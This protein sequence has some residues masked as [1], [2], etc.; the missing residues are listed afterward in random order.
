MGIKKF[1]HIKSII[2]SLTGFI[3]LLLIGLI[4]F[5]WLKLNETVSI[6]E[7]ISITIPNHSSKTEIISIFNSNGLLEPGWLYILLTKTYGKINGKHIYAGSYRILPQNTNFQILKAIFS[8]KQLNI[9]KVTFPEGITLHDFA[10]IAKRKLGIDSSEFINLTSSD[11]LLKAR[12]I[13]AKNLEGY[14]HP[15]TY[16]FYWKASGI[17]IID[18][19]LNSQDIIWNKQF[20]QPALNIG[21]SRHEILTLASIIEAET[22]VDS[23]KPRVAGVYYNRLR[24]GML[25]QADPTVQYAKGTKRKLN[26]ND[27]DYNS[28][29]NTYLYRGLPPGPIN[30]PGFTS[31]DAAINPESNNYYYFVATGDGSMKHNFSRNYNEHRMNIIKYKR[32]K[33]FK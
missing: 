29:Y 30:S 22:P 14:L 21:K 33:N 18:K 13:A 1:H 7:E 10:S 25:L 15:D 32:N 27:L 12:N 24:A 20:A 23:E 17:E 6:P 26:H 31:I 2:T 19:L 28:P 9:V 5:S 16:Q 8:G 4:I 11:S 3:I